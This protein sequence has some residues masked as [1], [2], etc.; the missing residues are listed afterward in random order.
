LLGNSNLT[1]CD[2]EPLDDEWSSGLFIAQDNWFDLLVLT[3]DET[4]FCDLRS[5]EPRLLLSSD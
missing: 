1:S 2:F 4:K 3:I 5:R